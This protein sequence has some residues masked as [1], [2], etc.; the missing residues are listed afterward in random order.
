[1]LSLFY[2]GGVFMWLL[3]AIAISIV[4]LAIKKA[5]YLFGNKI[6]NPKHLEGGI[7]TIIFWGAISIVIGFLSHFWGLYLAMEAI[8]KANDISPTIVANGFAVSLI[9]IIFGMLIFLFSAIIWLILRWK[10]KKLAT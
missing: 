9:T 3:L 1:M 4:I 6:T 7:N 2:K 10:Y 8:A 5:I